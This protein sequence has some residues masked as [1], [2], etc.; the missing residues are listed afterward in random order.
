MAGTKVAP[1]SPTHPPTWTFNDSNSAVQYQSSA[2]EPISALPPPHRPRAWDRLP[3]S[4]FASK[5]KGKG[6]KV[7]KRYEPPVLK[8]KTNE[9]GG[10]MLDGGEIIEGEKG[11]GDGAHAT[12]RLRSREK[13]LSHEEEKPS[14]YVT[15][16]KDK[17][18]GTPRRK[19][20]SRRSLR[21]DWGKDAAA[22]A[23]D[24][25]TTT[26]IAGTPRRTMVSARSSRVGRRSMGSE[27][28][29]PKFETAKTHNSVPSTPQRKMAPRRSL[30][31]GRNSLSPAADVHGV[32]DAQEQGNDSTTEHMMEDDDIDEPL[33][34]GSAQLQVLVEE[35]V[36]DIK[37]ATDGTAPHEA[38]KFGEVELDPV[39]P[40]EGPLAEDLEQALSSPLLPEIINKDTDKPLDS[41]LSHQPTEKYLIDLPGSKT[42]ALRE[43]SNDQDDPADL[44]GFENLHPSQEEANDDEIITLDG[45]AGQLAAD[46][47]GALD[48]DAS[49]STITSPLTNETSTPKNSLSMP[50]AS[51]SPNQDNLVC[52]G[53]LE[54]VDLQDVPVEVQPTVEAV[55][56]GTMEIEVQ[57]LTEEE[58]PQQETAYSQYAC[59]CK[60]ASPEKIVTRS[61]RRLSEKKKELAMSEMAADGEATSPDIN[62]TGSEEDANHPA[63]SESSIAHDIGLN[64]MSNIAS[65][66]SE[67]VIS[68]SASDHELHE[69]SLE[70]GDYTDHT[71]IQEDTIVQEPAEQDTDHSAQGPPT[72]EHDC[73]E[74][75]MADAES[76]TGKSPRKKTRSG[77]RFSD[78]T[79]I[80]K[81]FLSRAQAKKLAKDAAPAAN[82]PAPM[83]SPRRSSRKVLGNLDSKS[84]TGKPRDLTSRP[85]TPPDKVR[86]AEADMEESAETETGDASPVRRSTRKRLPAPAKTATGALSFIPVRRAD[87]TD[88]VKLQKSVAQELALVTQTN[89]RRNKGQSKPPAMILKTLTLEHYEEGTK[90]G[91]AL[92]NCKTVGWD[93]KLVYYQDGREALV[94]VESKPEEK[95]PQARRLR[96]LGAGNGTPAPK[97]KT[98]DT[99]SSNRTAASKGDGRMR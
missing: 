7:W 13:G 66:E 76:Q 41:P 46:C 10:Q 87:G 65:K 73:N 56:I 69:K 70:P 72:R 64:S 22:S 27:V 32:N 4:P 67:E 47:Q 20:A 97:R 28:V 8:D 40:T 79:T 60:P 1:A 81:D 26:K 63:G 14:K 53:D 71:G 99:L 85:G 86:L 75:N 93:K 92:R 55:E 74:L 2:P 18:P 15:T 94:D 89:T 36:G 42:F 57:P 44:P 52:A 17:V 91:H 98:A 45:I 6:R 34:N 54:D 21:P 77:T 80:L 39:Q 84:P 49:D 33:T 51:P 58:Q 82:L 59:P 35:E 83:P 9:R 50:R 25:Q 48:N 62:T 61:S 29:L 88:P 43:D 23:A 3:K 90:G 30:R 19:V 68:H 31:A 24:A 78:D 11:V 5:R 12:K 16:L 96:G 95:R 38:P 37:A